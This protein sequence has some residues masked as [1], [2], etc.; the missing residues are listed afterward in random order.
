MLS[1]GVAATMRQHAFFAVVVVAMIGGAWAVKAQAD[2]S[3]V[4]TT[5]AGRCPVTVPTRVVPDDAGF[6]A[7]GF[8]WGGARLRVHLYW[9]KGVLPVGILKDGGSYAIAADDGSIWVKLGWWRGIRGRLT[10]RGRR[11][12]APAPPVVAEV[13]DGYGD[14]GFVPSGLRFP[15]AGC[16]RVTGALGRARVGFV[17]KVR[18]LP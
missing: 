2:P 8:N 11:L 14:R 17:V 10:I 15:S 16:W 6:S 1:Y 9:P 12:D 13:P 3:G 5:N 4:A 18:L 7:E